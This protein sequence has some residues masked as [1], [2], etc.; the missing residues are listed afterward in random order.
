MAVVTA[1]LTAFVTG[2]VSWAV[3]ELREKFGT[4]KPDDE[5][6][7]DGKKSP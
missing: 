4:P 2:L 7:E 5:K 6:S 1:G 3:D